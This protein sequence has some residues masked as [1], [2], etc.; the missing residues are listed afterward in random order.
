MKNYYNDKITNRGELN[1]SSN[2]LFSLPRAI[3]MSVYDQ[4]VILN[5]SKNLLTEISEGMIKAMPNLKEL[6]ANNNKITFITSEIY[7]LK[8]TLKKLLLG[9]NNL[10]E[11]TPEISQLENLQ[12]LCI[13]NNKLKYL[14]PE[15]CELEKLKTLDVSDNNINSLP[16]ELGNLRNLKRLN[17]ENNPSLN[18]IP[19]SLCNLDKLERILLEW[20]IYVPRDVDLSINEHGQSKNV[21]PIYPIS[22]D[23]D[24]KSKKAQ[25]L[26]QILKSFDSQ[27]KEIVNFIDFIGCNQ[28]NIDYQDSRKRTKINIAAKEG[29]YLVV[30]ELL[31][32]GADPNV[33]DKDKFAALGLAIRESNDE[34]ASLLLSS[35]F[36]SDQGDIPRV[37][38]DIGAGNLGSPLHIS[39]VKHKTYIVKKMIKMGADP[40]IQDKEGNTPLHQLLSIFSKN[41]EESSA[42]LKILIENGANLQSVNT[43]GLTPLL[44]AIKKKQKGAILSVMKEPPHILQNFNPDFKEESSGYNSVYLLLKH[45]FTE[46]AEK[47]FLKGGNSLIHLPGGWKKCCVEAE[48]YKTKY[49][50]RKMRKFQLRSKFK[51]PLNTALTAPYED[52]VRNRIPFYE[53]TSDIGMSSPTEY[54]C[55]SHLIKKQQITKMA[56][57]H[58]SHETRHTRI[59][60]VKHKV[61]ASP[62]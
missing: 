34:I 19:T 52:L 1:Y 53:D 7:L 45:K 17:L 44:L 12:Y 28:D 26:R 61:P 49:I 18:S 30:K 62:E 32:E 10:E 27:G 13:N 4:V 31:K 22:S 47:M 3:M 40:N 58:K 39:V 60:F 36:Q 21:K 42:L 16:Y 25:L 5:I 51:V 8:D 38:L 20:L 24:I 57:I 41:E 35:K 55:V 43:L 29:H 50:I 33:Y 46:L 37:D 9:C 2:S 54:H 48:S 15:I 23:A 6:I 11:I 59:K 14:P 56:L